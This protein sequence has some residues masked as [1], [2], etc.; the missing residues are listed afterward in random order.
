[1]ESEMTA[2]V[3]AK[4]V[5][6]MAQRHWPAPCMC[7][8]SSSAHVHMGRNSGVTNTICSYLLHDVELLLLHALLVTRKSL[9]RCTSCNVQKVLS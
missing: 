4:Q 2:A 7:M 3:E 5:C 1:M 9:V 8:A 6:A